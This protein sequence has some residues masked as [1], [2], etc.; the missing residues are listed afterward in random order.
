[1]SRI[2]IDARELRT[3]SGRYAERLLFYL[4]L[5]D[6]TNEYLVLVK[7]SDLDNWSPSGKNF[8]KILCPYKEFT[9][10]EQIG[11]MKQI[12]SLKPDLV[13]FTFTQQPILYTGKVITTIHDLT[14]LRFDNPD[15]NFIVFKIKQFIYGLVTKRVARKSKLVITDSEYVRN[16]VSDYAHIPKSKIKVIYEAADKITDN[17]APVNS[18]KPGSYIMYLGRP[19]PHKNLERLVEAF[20]II[21]KVRPELQLVLA[22]KSDANYKRIEDRV[23]NKGIENIVFTGFVSEGQLRWLYENCSAYVF[24]S[25]S[26]GFGLPGLEA[27]SAG[28]TVVSSNATC[29]HEI[30]GDAAEYFDP[31]N[32]EEMANSIERV[33]SDNSLRGDLIRRGYTQ[34]SKYSWETTAKQTLDLYNQCL[35]N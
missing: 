4:Q 33:L 25:L 10:G 12:K 9:F 35:N 22:G 27:M 2:V 28:A 11:L 30:Y 20:E 26:E 17:P 32:V 34:A 31:I 3:S 14:T 29:L 18:V 6:K 13:H 1:M 19:T 16:D 21:Q 15:K 5:V 24:P 8:Q 7:P 23:K